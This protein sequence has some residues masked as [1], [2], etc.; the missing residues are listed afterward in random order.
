M[1]MTRYIYIA[2]LLILVLNAC[3]SSTNTPAQSQA[4]TI[5]AEQTSGYPGPQAVTTNPSYPYPVPSSRVPNTPQPTFTSDPQMGSVIGKLLVNNN[6]VN[7]VTLYLAG[8]IKDATG[9]DIVAGLDRVNSPN[10]ATDEQ[11]IF[12]FINIK[13]GRYALILDVVINQYLMNYPDKDGTIIFQ[14]DSGK[15]VDLGDLNYDSLPLP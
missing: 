1:K 10:T 12:T 6:G 5:T 9:K 8:I 15:T 13:P 2:F 14:I 3:T 11:G 4:P 7:N